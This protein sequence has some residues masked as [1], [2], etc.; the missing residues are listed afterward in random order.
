MVTNKKASCRPKQLTP[1]F[2]A[3]DAGFEATTFGSGDHFEGFPQLTDLT[4]LSY[5]SSGSPVHVLFLLLLLHSLCLKCGHKYV[6]GSS[7]LRLNPAILHVDL[8][9]KKENSDV[10]VHHSPQ[11]RRIRMKI[12]HSIVYY[13]TL[14]KLV[15]RLNS[16]K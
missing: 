2:K 9:K 11:E 3:G 6:T 5:I 10:E 4:K 8:G 12:T 15:N 16:G 1:C 13:I 14:I 7:S